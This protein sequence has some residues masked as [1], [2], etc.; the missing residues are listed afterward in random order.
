MKLN[1]KH[2]STF[3]LLVTFSTSALAQSSISITDA[4]TTLTTTPVNCVPPDSSL[5]TLSIQNLDST[6]SIGYCFRT[7]TTPST[8]CTPAIG[9]VGTYTITAGSLF[10]WG[11]GEVPKN[12]LD[13]IGAASVATSIGLGH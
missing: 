8:K 3:M 1:L 6:N 11:P 5:K 4:S 7:A 2:L 10:F 13:C 9:S 12:G